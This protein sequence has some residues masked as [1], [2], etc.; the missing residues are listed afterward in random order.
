MNSNYRCY[1]YEFVDFFRN[2]WCFIFPL[3]AYLKRER[4][5]QD[6]KCNYIDFVIIG[7]FPWNYWLY[8]HRVLQFNRK[9]LQK[10]DIFQFNLRFGL[11]FHFNSKWMSMLWL[12]RVQLN[13]TKIKTK[14]KTNPEDFHVI[15]T[16][17]LFSFKF[18]MITYFVYL[19]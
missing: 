15:I 10:F 7:K 1:L 18:D 4:D 6:E 3:N 5:K 17:C 8:V 12:F 2:K 19:K 11:C 14:T 9:L 16:K 13:E